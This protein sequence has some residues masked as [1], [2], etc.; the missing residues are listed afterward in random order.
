MAIY[1]EPKDGDFVRYIE[2][3]NRQAG[4]TPGQVLPRKRAGRT[5]TKWKTA[6]EQPTTDDSVYTYAPSAQLP[7]ASYSEDNSPG[8]TRNEEQQ[9]PTLAARSGQRHLAL[10]LSIAGFVALWNAITQLFTAVNT[11]TLDFDSAVPIVFLV[12]CAL[13]L[14]KGASSARKNQHKPLPKLPPLSVV[15]MGRSPKD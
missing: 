10:A 15:H 1:G 3:L 9:P 7:P 5:I 8:A 14:F 12:V 6:T 13:M 2:T 11:G 4:V